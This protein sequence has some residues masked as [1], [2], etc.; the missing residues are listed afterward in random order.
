MN[1]DWM[2]ARGYDPNPGWTSLRPKL[3]W[4]DTKISDVADDIL[5]KQVHAYKIEKGT[6]EEALKLMKSAEDRPYETDTLL[7]FGL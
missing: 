7:V 5:G 6:I 4:F 2:I 1:D 3:S